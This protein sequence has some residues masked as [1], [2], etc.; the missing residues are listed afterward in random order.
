MKIRKNGFSL[1]E[2]IIVVALLAI[3][4]FIGYCSISLIFGESKKIATTISEKNIL[5]TTRLYSMEFRDSEKW[6]EEVNQNLN[7]EYD[8]CVKVSSLVNYGYFKP[9]EVSKYIDSIVKLEIKDGVYSYDFT[10]EI[11]RCKY[12]EYGLTIDDDFGGTIEFDEIKTLND[13][14]SFVEYE[15]DKQNNSDYLL[16]LDG[17]FQFSIDDLNRNIPTYVSVVLDDSASMFCK[18]PDMICDNGDEDCYMLCKENKPINGYDKATEAAY[19]LFNKIDEIDYA[20]MAGIKYAMYITYNSGFTD[21]KE[22]INFGQ[23]G[24]ASTN[25]GVGLEFTASI[26]NNEIKKGIDIINSSNIYTILLFDGASNFYTR[27][28]GKDYKCSTA[29]VHGE[30]N[31]GSS[32]NVVYEN[33]P[34]NNF[35]DSV[36]TDMYMPYEEKNG[37]LYLGYG[38]TY[39]NNTNWCNGHNIRPYSWCTDSVVDSA[40]ILRDKMNSKIIV[41]GYNFFKDDFLDDGRTEEQYH[42]TMKIASKASDVSFCENSDYDGYCYYDATSNNI[43]ELFEDISNNIVNKVNSTNIKK[44]EIIIE[45]NSVIFDNSNIIK[46]SYVFENDNEGEII[47][48]LNNIIINLNLKSNSELNNLTETEFELFNLKFNLYDD[49]NSITPVSVIQKNPNST[50]KLNEILTIN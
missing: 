3:L 21:S 34:L 23:C 13:D 4:L 42:N 24:G 19:N 37:K 36:Y 29:D 45:P 47:Q 22:N 8:F 27:I 32:H 41:I 39:C 9:K 15:F 12:I 14:K 44:V 10:E 2:L 28:N 38:K 40:Q 17:I 20:K 25:I 33:Y 18:N 49:I 43:D 1:I 31:A 7:N 46:Q 26:L 50:I 48:E 11:D 6:K 16:K 35:L 5:N 30:N